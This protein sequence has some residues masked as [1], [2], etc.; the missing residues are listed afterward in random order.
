MKNF[1]EW[2]KSKWVKRILI[3]VVAL[4]LIALVAFVLVLECC[5]RQRPFADAADYWAQ[6][7]KHR[8]TNDVVGHWNF[9]MGTVDLIS[10][11]NKHFFDVGEPYRY[12]KYTEWCDQFR[13]D[14]EALA[15]PG[16]D[17]GKDGDYGWPA[18]MR[19]M[20]WRYAELGWGWALP[21]IAIIE[22]GRTREV[23]FNLAELAEFHRNPS[24][25]IDYAIY[26]EWGSPTR[27]NIMWKGPQAMLEGLYELIS[28]DRERF[29]EEFQTICRDLYGEHLENM[30]K[31][32]GEGHTAGVCCE[33]NH[34]FPQ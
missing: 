31:P 27:E 5:I 17:F 19:G 13:Y 32:V 1:Y 14:T 16:H 9:G 28:G 15:R 7:G 26:Q 3:G 21:S 33:A 8:L 24:G 11:A 10:Y 20:G 18:S 23:A 25:W 22:P 34:W 6:L 2:L 12:E 30:A 29:G 4:V